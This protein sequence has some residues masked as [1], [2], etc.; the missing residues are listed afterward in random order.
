MGAIEQVPSSVSRAGLEFN[1]AVW[2]PGTRVTLCS[3]PWDSEYR[4]IVKFGSRSAL[5]DY[6]QGTP[7]NVITLDRTTYLKVGQ[8]VHL[9]VPFNGSYRFNYLRVEQSLPGQGTRSYYYFIQDVEYVGLNNTRFYVQLDIWQTF[10]YEIKF[11]QC[12]LEQGHI[13]VANEKQMFDNGREYLTTPEGFDLGGE[14]GIT[15]VY[16]DILGQT[17]AGMY[18]VDI[19]VASTVS[20]EKS[21]GDVEKP[22]MVS[23]EGSDFEGLPNACE[24]Y[25]FKDIASF[26]QQLEMMADKPWITAGIVSIMAVP[27]IENPV[28]ESFFPPYSSYQINR[29]KGSARGQYK[30]RTIA[31]SGNWRDFL[32][33]KHFP[34]RYRHLKKFQTYP[35]TVVELTTHSGTPL[36]LKPESMYGND[37][38]V[39][40]MT[41]YALPGPRIM[42]SPFKYNALRRTDN[43]EYWNPIPFN[44]NDSAE[45][46]DMATGITN[47]PTFSVLNN[48]YMQY[49][50]SNANSI[51]YQHQS[52]D[53]SQQK[54]L[55]GNSLSAN[56]STAGMANTM[57][58]TQVGMQA[59]QNSTEITNQAAAWQTGIGVGGNLIS[60]AQ[61]GA[62]GL[63][64]AGLASAG[65]VLSQVVQTDARNAQ[66]ANSIA[67]Q[68]ATM[69]NDQGLGMYIRD[70]N[71]AYAD[72]AANG[73]YQNAIAGINAKTQDAKLIQPTTSGQLGGDAFMLAAYQWEIAAKIKTLMPNAMAV[74]GEIWLRYGYA[75]NR[76]ATPP[77]S[78]KCMTKFTYWKMK[79]TYIT[80]AECPESFKQGIRGI[81]EKGVTVWSDPNDIG[82][83]DMADNEP[84]KG[85]S[86]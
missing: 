60:G 9:D 63:A 51:A 68:R 20:W 69:R 45:F 77:E 74:I 37:I 53:W 39:T 11:G 28:L 80:G 38:Q 58:N 8:P 75:V 42:F 72:M 70:S 52:A 41:H 71:K 33:D 12:F 25:W 46:V 49:M 22:I 85:I 79:E 59:M 48:S 34:E 44:A 21:G 26:Q 7:L 36:L 43:G 16:T 57:A 76:F 13:G 73:D 10:G 23:A 18:S 62:A 2:S 4:D 27:T 67:A 65:S 81:F 86:L 56:Q 19:L 14:Y 50:A 61:G 29:L 31:G 6:I 24:L 66:T 5:D 82:N 35:Y 3:V 17:Q 15:R 47:F 32:S 30:I 84:L 54:A 83:I 64:A 55:T 1:Y 78:L 40:E